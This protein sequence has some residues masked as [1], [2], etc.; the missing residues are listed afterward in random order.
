MEF[1]AGH[2]VDALEAPFQQPVQQVVTVRQ[3]AVAGD[4]QLQDG[5]VAQRAGENEDAADIV[6]QLMPDAVDLGPGFDA[7]GSHV[8]V[9]VELQEDP[10]FGIRRRRV[11]ALHAGQGSERL[12]HGAGYQALDFLRRRTFVRDLDKDSRK[13]D[14]RE[15]LER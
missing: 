14:V 8:L 1:D 9:P 15:F 5:L 6:G 2:S 7:L 3:V 13:L 11:H 4:P 12:F 10:R